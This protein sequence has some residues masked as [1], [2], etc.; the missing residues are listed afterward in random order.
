MRITFLIL[1][2]ILICASGISAQTAGL[3]SVC[4]ANSGIG[5]GVRPAESPWSLLDMS[6]ISWSH[7]YSGTY[8]SGGSSSGSLGMFNS[9]MMYDISSK[10]SLSVDTGGIYIEII[11]G[12]V[13][14]IWI[15]S[16]RDKV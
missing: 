3:P 6:R 2:L 9:T 5:F 7:S 4:P 11:T 16:N 13:V 14:M 1:S 8:F 12:L 15:Q 10:L